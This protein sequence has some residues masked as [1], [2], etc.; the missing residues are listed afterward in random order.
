MLLTLRHVEPLST[1]LLN[2][3]DPSID[4]FPHED[5]Q[6]FYRL[7]NSQFQL[8]FVVVNSIYGGDCGDYRQLYPY[9]I[10]L[11]PATK[12][13]TPQEAGYELVESYGKSGVLNEE[14]AYQSLDPFTGE[15][16]I[17]S[18][19]D[20]ISAAG[21]DSAHT[22]EIGLIHDY[23]F[24]RKDVDL[25]YVAQ[26]STGFEGDRERRYLKHRAKLLYKPFSKTDAR[27]VW[28]VENGLEL[29]LL[30]EIVRVGLPWP[31]IQAHIYDDGA[32]F[33]SLYH[34]WAERETMDDEHFVTEV[35]FYFPEQNV[36]LFCDGATHSRKKVRERDE[37]INARLRE[38][39][40]VVVRIPS[41]AI[42]R[43][44]KAAVQ[45]LIDALEAAQA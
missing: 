5:E 42:L 24:L 26:P 2:K 21:Q 27:Q 1:D 14:W 7:N 28:G 13:Q 33:P 32:A 20:V 11:V 35:D 30:H 45:P 19:L 18:T 37:R 44:V 25:D 10:S 6:Q 3:I 15:W 17:F 38:L 29:F 36:A 39:G 23:F 12:R 41:K 4:D 31:V 9:S 16:G 43:D 8:V 40:I 22:D 34:A